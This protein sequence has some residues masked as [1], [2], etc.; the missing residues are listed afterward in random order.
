MNHWLLDTVTVSEL[1]KDTNRQDIN[2]AKWRERTLLST[3]W[4]SVITILEIKTGMLQ[5]Q[6]KDPGFAA[7]L[8]VWLETFVMKRFR[9]RILDIDT[10]VVQS[11][12]VY[13]AKKNLDVADALIAATAETHGL[14]LV[15]R[16]VSDF[17]ET[18]LELL[19]PWKTTEK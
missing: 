11:A 14:T 13:R 17:E 4:L 1:R 10:K 12:A 3:C 7:R 2:V 5:V 18:E 15:T 16:N 8:K 6:S 9:Y 19:N